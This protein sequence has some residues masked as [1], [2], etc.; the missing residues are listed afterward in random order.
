MSHYSLSCFNPGARHRLCPL[1]CFLV[2][3]SNFIKLLGDAVNKVKTASFH[4]LSS[5]LVACVPVLNA[6]KCGA[7]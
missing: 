6:V 5:S 7:S 2:F 1:E 3:F 4:F